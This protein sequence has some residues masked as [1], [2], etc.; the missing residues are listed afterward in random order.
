MH[1]AI[2]YL[3]QNTAR[4]AQYGRDSRTLLE[5]SLDLLYTHYHARFRHDVLIF[6]EGDFDVEAQEAVRRGRPE[7]H[8]QKVDFSLPA[9]LDPAS[10]P[11]E[12]T[13]GKGA[14]FGMG[15]RHMCRFY[16]VE[17][18]DRLEALGYDWFFRMDDDS[19]LHSPI[20]YDLFAF[21]EERNLTYGYRVDV[22]EAPR[23]SRGFAELVH[24]YA[25]AEGIDLSGFQHARVSIGRRLQVFAEAVWHELRRAPARAPSQPYAHWCYY[26]NFFITPLAFWKS[27]PVQQFLRFLD[28]S[29]GIYR[30]RWNDLLIQSAAVQL[31][32]R[33]EQI[34]K[35]TDWSYEHASIAGTTVRWGGYYPAPNDTSGAAQFKKTYG[36]NRHPRTWSR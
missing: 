1:P 2:V 30:Y 23:C 22:L 18:F 34:H 29:G 25:L 27:E 35:F 11:T 36:C 17:L 12:W 20:D 10:V 9:F 5:K 13:D 33:P 21:M 6:H 3:A 14:R 32:L 15:H 31:F 8:F 16:A 24:A 19:F 28:R 26:N 4:D 7:I